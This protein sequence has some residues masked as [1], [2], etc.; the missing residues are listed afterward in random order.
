MHLFVT[1]S[2]KFT[3]LLSTVIA[4]LGAVHVSASKCKTQ[5]TPEKLEARITSEGYI[6]SLSPI[7]S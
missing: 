1:M 6:S 4:L 2:P 5:L 3:M 7:Q